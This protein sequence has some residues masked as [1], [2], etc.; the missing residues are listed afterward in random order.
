MGGSAVGQAQHV[1]RPEESPVRDV[2][3]D[4]IYEILANRR[5]RYVLHYL[6][7]IEE[8]VDLG[9]LAEQVAAWEYDTDP[10]QVTSQQRKTVYTA[11]QQRHLPRMDEAEL[12][13][14]DQR[15]GTVEPTAALADIDIYTEIVPEGG[16][17]WSQYYLGL[18]TLTAA[19]MMAVWANIP[20]L[21]VLPDIAWGIFCA[22]A[23]LVSS[24][25]HAVV[26]RGMKLGTA[27]Q[28]PEVD[29]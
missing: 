10:E 23:F 7:Y 8:A 18:A 24:A 16:F 17:P 14:F 15:A 9:T 27:E 1:V 12:V 26:T 28:P 6:Q 20:P 13:A 25:V 29:V 3:R 21:G 11:L 2:S 22:T 19:L 5:R 4:T